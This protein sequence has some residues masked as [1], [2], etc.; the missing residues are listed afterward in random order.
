MFFCHRI[1][2]YHRIHISAADEKCQPRLSEHG[3]AVLILPVRLGNNSNTVACALQKPAD[4]GGTERRMIYIGVPDYID[5]VAL[6]PS[7]PFHILPAD[8]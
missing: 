2:I 6:L 4:N 1:M 5:E 8:R 3:N 7:P